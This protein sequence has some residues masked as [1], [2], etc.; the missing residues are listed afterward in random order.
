MST[1]GPDPG[2]TPAAVVDWWSTA[3]YERWF[4]KDDA[5]DARFTARFAAAHEEAA[6]GALD[7]W[8]ATA[9]GAL[10]L[11]I[12]L[13]QYPRNAFRG[14][15]R[16][17]ATDARALALAEAAIAAGHDHALPP[18]LRLFLYLPMEHAEDLALQERAVALIAPLGEEVA[19]YAEIHR[20]V[21]ARFGRFP[22]R[23]AVLGRETTAAEQAFLDAGGFAG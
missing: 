4:G 23:N 15:A 8:A 19:R 2:D 7:H 1:P 22:H 14:T 11:V 6:S 5:F 16:Q 13:D 12:L 21:I 17:F 18:D 9:E 20:D 10:A 3:G